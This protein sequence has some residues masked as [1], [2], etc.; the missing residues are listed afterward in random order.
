MSSAREW[1][2]GLDVVE[3]DSEKLRTLAHPTRSRIVSSLRLEGPATSSILASRLATN[4]GQTSYHLRAL[5][6]VGLVVEDAD[7]GTARER[8]WK[9]AQRGHSWSEPTD[10]ADPE[11]RHAADWLL[12][13]YHRLYTQWVSEW[14]EQR[15]EWSPEWR[16]A[17]VNGDSF[18]LSTPELLEEFNAEL[19]DLQQ[20][21]QDL[22]NELDP[23]DPDVSR[24]TFIRHAFPSEHVRP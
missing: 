1:L 6:D 3:L 13:H 9:A 20:R 4:S 12:R 18:M 10:E 14:F 19:N 23:D 5:A 11:D 24:V 17:A 7:R 22:G 15:Q 8:W 21:Y 16:H 2:D